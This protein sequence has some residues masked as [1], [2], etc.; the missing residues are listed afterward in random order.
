MIFKILAA[1]IF[2]KTLNIP[3]LLTLISVWFCSCNTTT[4]GKNEFHAEERILKPFTTVEINQKMNLTAHLTG[5]DEKNRIVFSAQPNIIPLILTTVENEKLLI[6]S[7]KSIDTT[8]VIE[9][10]IYCNGPIPIENESSGVLKFDENYF[11][12]ILSPIE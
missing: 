6:S 10:H 8:T 2:L 11:D 7:A 12:E 5:P 4:T 1:K 3:V 9:A